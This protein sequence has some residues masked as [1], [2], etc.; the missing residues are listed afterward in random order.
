MKNLNDLV[1]DIEAI[2]TQSRNRAELNSKVSNL[3]TEATSEKIRNFRI[4]DKIV[5]VMALKLIAAKAQ[6]LAYDL[7]NGKLW[8]GQLADGIAEIRSQLTDAGRCAG[9][10]C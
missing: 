4:E 6:K 7:E 9:R 10:G 8:E 5:A 3:L 2:V 1:T